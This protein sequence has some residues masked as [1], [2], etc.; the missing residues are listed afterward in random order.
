MKVILLSVVLIGSIATAEPKETPMHRFNR[1]KCN[2]TDEQKTQVGKS[3]VVPMD[4]VGNFAEF[5]LS[6]GNFI[7]HI[8]KLG[9]LAYASAKGASG[10]VFFDE[11][12]NPKGWLN[13]IPYGLTCSLL[14]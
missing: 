6:Y 4:S 11:N 3:V 7:A 14:K 9:H 2:L 8:V 1:I 13:L 10:V 5:D 12:G